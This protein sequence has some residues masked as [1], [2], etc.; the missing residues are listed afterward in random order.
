M[1]V[2]MQFKNIFFPAVPLYE[3]LL[4]KHMPNERNRTLH[5]TFGSSH[6]VSTFNDE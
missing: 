1:S 2:K 5:H 3:A 6:E 4:L